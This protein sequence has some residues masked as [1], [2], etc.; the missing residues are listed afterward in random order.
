MKLINLLCL[1]FIFSIV[2]LTGQ[3]LENEKYAFSEKISALKLRSAVHEKE[4]SKLLSSSDLEPTNF[5]VPSI[6]TPLPQPPDLQSKVPPAPYLPVPDYFEVKEPSDVSMPTVPKGNTDISYTKE[7]V[8]TESGV[9]LNSSTDSMDV[10]STSVPE[11]VFVRHDGY[12]FGPLLGF[13]IPDDG[14]VRDGGIAGTG[15]IPFES[16]AGYFLGLQFGKDFGT[17][18]WEVEYSHQ[19][20]DAE[21]LNQGF[22]VGIHSFVT[23]LLLEKEIGGLFDL[24][25]GLGMGVG[26]ISLES[27][28]DFSGE[29]FI[30]DFSTGASYRFKENMSIVLDYRFFLSAAE[31]RYDRINSHIFT[32]SAHFDL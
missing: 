16:D 2:F 28:Q 32:A 3:Q 13:T 22:E 4:I 29:S 1:K 14:A 31:D 24:R 7:Y 20:F 18:R 19:G 9:D 27:V 8:N 5:G 26:F 25:A 21:G 12:Y 30:Y 17:V 11:T 23:R 10:E 6:L 15:K